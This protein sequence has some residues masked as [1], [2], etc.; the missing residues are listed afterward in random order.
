[1]QAIVNDGLSSDLPIDV[2]P[3]V[4]PLTGNALHAKVSTELENETLVSENSPLDLGPTEYKDQTI[5]TVELADAECNEVDQELGETVATVQALEEYS[6]LL[7]TAGATGVSPQ[8]VQFLK[9]GLEHI[10]TTMFDGQM[11]HAL[12]QYNPKA[13]VVSLED[14]IKDKIKAGI[15]RVIKLFKMW[16]DRIGVYYANYKNGLN[17][18][19]AKVKA[20]R[21]KLDALEFVSDVEVKFM[22]TSGLSADGKS[23]IND[24]SLVSGLTQFITADYPDFLLATYKVIR[25]ELNQADPERTDISELTAKL[26]DELADITPE[27]PF[28]EVA[29]FPGN[30]RLK[31]TKNSNYKL[32]ED[33]SL[34]TLME[35]SYVV[36]DKRMMEIRLKN[37]EG[38]L[39]TLNK[40]VD[41]SNDV[42]K[43]VKQTQD[44][45]LK[46]MKKLTESDDVST[47]NL[48]ALLSL[49]EDNKPSSEA[50]LTYLI[51][52]VSQY[53]A[54]TE[55]EIRLMTEA[56]SRDD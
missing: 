28:N 41:R 8:T 3:V 24:T 31:A 27:I 42:T 56:K 9:V 30:V 20:T 16:L 11:S 22:N 43:T 1:M 15:A 26:K 10:E 4:D 7:R 25:D 33:K 54:V 14:S 55:Q 38:I 23:L 49:L 34:K 17:R 50:V 36:T 35:H 48:T 2:P 5:E 44:S 45:I 29:V 19:N 46:F 40:A 37:I 53:L 47:A 13:E 52:T 39:D 12:E 32:E 51:K 18:L 6:Q 21:V